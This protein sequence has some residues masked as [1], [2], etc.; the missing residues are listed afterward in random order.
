ML[1]AFCSVETLEKTNFL[2]G[3]KHIGSFTFT[4]VGTEQQKLPLPAS[5]TNI[6]EAPF[7]DCAS[8]ACIRLN[9]HNIHYT[10]EDGVLYDKSKILL[11]QYPE[12]KQNTTSVTS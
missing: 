5:I 11:V 2:E 1:F 8:L 10:T 6:H 7:H 3:L 12:A 9:A 4:Q